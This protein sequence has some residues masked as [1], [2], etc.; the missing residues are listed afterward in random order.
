MVAE[1]AS[2]A[3]QLPTE[4]AAVAFEPA[5]R[6][7]N[8]YAACGHSPCFVHNGSRSAIRPTRSPSDQY[9][10]MMLSCIHLDDA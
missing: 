9:H 5:I 6:C 1:V 8:Q 3:L 4:S 2:V 10:L 7:F